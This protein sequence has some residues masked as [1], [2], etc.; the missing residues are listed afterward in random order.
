MKKYYFNWYELLKKSKKDYDSIIVLTYASTF[1][2]NKKIANGSLDLIK[3]LYVDRV[4]SWLKNQ[5]KINTQ[6]FELFNNYKTEEPQS[7]FLN[8]DFLTTY[9]KV[10]HKIQY[11]WLLSYRRIDEESPY[12]KRD[13]LRLKEIDGIKNNPFI[14][15][16]DDKIN[17]IFE[18]TYTQRT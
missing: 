9:T 12:I 1:G 13:Y 11:L 8:K 14:S 7:Y 17:F 3:T 5:I 6:S 4:P 15:I 2:Y 18:N 16:E 10:E